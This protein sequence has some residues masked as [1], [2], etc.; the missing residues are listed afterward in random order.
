ME[1]GSTEFNSLLDQ[2]LCLDYG[3]V[4]HPHFLPKLSRADVHLGTRADRT[5]T[6]AEKI[7]G[8]E[9]KLIGK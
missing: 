1:S 9:A 5:Q 7:L 2:G 6:M 4:A 3:A 8:V